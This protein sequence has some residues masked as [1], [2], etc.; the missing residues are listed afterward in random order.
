LVYDIEE[1]RRQQS[2]DTL[3]ALKAEMG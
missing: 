1:G 3:D 2:W